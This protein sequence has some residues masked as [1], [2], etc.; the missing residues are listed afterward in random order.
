MKQ[1]AYS[2][3]D[4]G[5]ALKAIYRAAAHSTAEKACSSSRACS[6]ITAELQ[7]RIVERRKPFVKCIF[8]NNCRLTFEAF[9]IRKNGGLRETRLSE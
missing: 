7:L 4:P 1:P 9:M 5:A 8:R 6:C 2:C 3:E